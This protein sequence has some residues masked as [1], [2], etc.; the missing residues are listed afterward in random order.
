MLSSSHSPFESLVSQV[1]TRAPLAPSPDRDSYIRAPPTQ[2]QEVQHATK[3]YIP[4][5]TKT[6]RKPSKPF[7]QTSENS[8][9]RSQTISSSTDKTDFSNAQR[10]APG[11]LQSLVSK[12]G[13][14]ISSQHSS[15]Y[16]S[17]LKPI[18]EGDESYPLKSDDEIRQTEVQLAD[19]EDKSDSLDDFLLI[20][21]EMKSKL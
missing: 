4:K 5:K 7:G 14:S 15:L 9:S 18:A 21:E 19:K 2:I 12:Q 8:F 13:K 1:N 20:E 11:Y 3:S 17:G 6:A 16:E 10:F